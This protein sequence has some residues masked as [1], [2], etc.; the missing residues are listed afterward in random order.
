MRNVIPLLKRSPYS[1]RRCLSEVGDGASLARQP[2]LVLFGAPKRTKKKV[3]NA[4]SQSQKDNSSRIC[5]GS[6]M[7]CSKISERN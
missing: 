1:A 7:L 2:F 6:L 4:L 3:Y 5:T